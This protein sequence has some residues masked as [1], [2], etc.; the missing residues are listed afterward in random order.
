MT[1]MYEK[2]QAIVMV[3][4]HEGVYMASG[5]GGAQWY[6][7]VKSDQNWNGTD[8]VFAVECTLNG[9]Q[10]YSVSDLTIVVT[11]NNT[12]AGAKEIKNEFDCS[13][14]GNKVT[15]K[16]NK[17]ME[18]GPGDKVYANLWVHTDDQGTTEGLSAT[19]CTAE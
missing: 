17:S 3:E 9:G 5:V 16:L 4:N 2:P 14:E 6:V 12:L 11:F 10:T 15:L 7:S 19:F 1:R 8:H 18:C 13:L